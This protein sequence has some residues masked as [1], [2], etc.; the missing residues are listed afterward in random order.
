MINYT[1]Q[2]QL[3]SR[4]L[5]DVVAFVAVAAFLLSRVLFSIAA[6]AQPCCFF[7]VTVANVHL[8]WFYDV[9]SACALICWGRYVL[10]VFDK[11]AY[12]SYRE[13]LFAFVVQVFGLCATSLCLC[14]LLS[15]EMSR[16]CFARL[17]MYF[18]SN[19]IS[20]SW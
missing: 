19:F 8:R 13:V 11:S 7:V 12:F 1:K 18:L 4:L 16:C 9:F 20:G 3:L 15:C 10:V 14:S 6:Q 2:K 17:L 5:L